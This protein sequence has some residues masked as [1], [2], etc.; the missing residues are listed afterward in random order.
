MVQFKTELVNEH[1][2]TT[3]IVATC[4][5]GDVTIAVFAD[6]DATPQAMTLTDLEAKAVRSL[7][8]LSEPA[9]K[10]NP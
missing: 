6:D 9:Y 2:V 7:L 1:G 3:H 4:E 8:W 5:V 10:S